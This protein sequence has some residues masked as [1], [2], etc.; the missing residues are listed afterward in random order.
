MDLLDALLKDRVDEG[1]RASARRVWR[2]AKHILSV[3]TLA[4]NPSN[5]LHPK[6]EKGGARR[7]AQRPGRSRS[8]F[9]FVVRDSNENVEEPTLW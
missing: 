4:R 5:Y 8:P 2:L 3:S 1:A 6:G 7:T 9:P